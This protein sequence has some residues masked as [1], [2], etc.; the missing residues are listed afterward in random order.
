M[1]LLQR[2]DDY[3]DILSVPAGPTWSLQSPKS[4]QRTHNPSHQPTQPACSTSKYKDTKC[5]ITKIEGDKSLDQR[6]ETFHIQFTIYCSQCLGFPSSNLK[7]R[8]N[9][10]PQS[11]YISVLALSLVS[12]IFSNTDLASSDLWRPTF[13]KIL[14]LKC[15]SFHDS[16]LPHV[17]QS[18][19]VSFELWK[20]SA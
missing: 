16:D 5:K 15:R 2:C 17:R 10:R 11:I 18:T 14:L 4:D 8:Y 20:R 12:E 6:M 7:R 13:I 1:M 9:V 19:F 3:T